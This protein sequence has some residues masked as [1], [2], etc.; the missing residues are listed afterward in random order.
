MSMS[1]REWDEYVKECKKAFDLKVEH[2]A[3][4]LYSERLAENT[5]NLCESDLCLLEMECEKEAYNQ[6]KTTKR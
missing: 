2:L 3:E 5:E 6:L 4:K 1:K